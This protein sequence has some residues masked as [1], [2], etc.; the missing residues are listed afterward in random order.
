MQYARS[1][2][3]NVLHVLELHRR[4]LADE[5]HITSYAVSPGRVRT[6]IFDNLPP[7]ARA[8][9]APIVW[10]FFQTPQ[11]VPLPADMKSCTTS[12]CLLRSS[13]ANAY[14]YCLACA[15]MAVHGCHGIP[16][17]DPDVSSC[18]CSEQAQDTSQAEMHAACAQG[19]STV[20][21]AALSPEMEGRNVLYLHGCKEAQ[22]SKLG[23]DRALAQQ[24]WL[25]SEQAVG[26]E[27][28]EQPQ[29]QG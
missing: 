6:Q 10:A 29:T 28:L 13:T 15:H 1:K 5:R 2:L 3:C 23:Q 21:Y 14:I 17:C 16:Q 27:G 7:V 24:L 18:H 8:L 9:L 12:L 20:L 4:L 22:A 26:E 19:A 11:Q 25:A